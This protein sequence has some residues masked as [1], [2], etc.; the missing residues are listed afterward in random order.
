MKVMEIE[1]LEAFSRTMLCGL[2]PMRNR[3]SSKLISAFPRWMELF[4]EGEE[5]R[6]ESDEVSASVDINEILMRWTIAQKFCLTEHRRFGHV[7]NQ[8]QVG[9]RICVLVGGEVPFVIRPT[10]RGTYILAG[11]CYV[12]GIM[13]GEA[14]ETG[15]AATDLIEGLETIQLE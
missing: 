7:A 3:V 13:D 2:D 10:G 6:Y 11:P 1:S 9:D 14:L 5:E 15:Y 4:I 12:D 8:S